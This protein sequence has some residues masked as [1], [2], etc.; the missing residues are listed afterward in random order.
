MVKFHMRKLKPFIHI[1]SNFHEFLSTLT[2]SAAAVNWSG[3]E[4]RSEETHDQ[5]S[6]RHFENT[7]SNLFLYVE[8]SYLVNVK[9]NHSRICWYKQF[10]S[11][12]HLALLTGQFLRV[13][14][15]KASPQQR[16]LTKTFTGV[17]NRQIHSDLLEIYTIPCADVNTSM[18]Q[19]LFN[20][21][22]DYPQKT[23]RGDNWPA[24][25]TGRLPV[26]TKACFGTVLCLFVILEIKLW[27]S[28][29]LFRRFFY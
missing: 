12:K 2:S 25:I 16:F 4:A 6:P 13:V 27:E 9:P 15:S 20:F 23:A 22:K 17:G 19:K 11:P 26:P 18:Y 24:A 1:L 28:H 8:C 14:F 10:Y 29:W 21:M 3:S 7:G 5:L